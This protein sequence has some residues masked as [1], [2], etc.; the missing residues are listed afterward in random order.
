MAF[1]H[2]T[3]TSNRNGAAARALSIPQLRADIKGE[4]ITP[5]DAGYDAARTVFYGG[6]DRHPALIIRVA[7]ARMTSRGSSRWRAKPA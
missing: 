5:E 2:Q 1:D 3:A 7:D 6:I 4:V